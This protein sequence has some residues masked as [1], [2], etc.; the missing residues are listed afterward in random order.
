MVMTIGIVLNNTNW[1]L[2]ILYPIHYEEIIDKYAIEYNLDPHLI[3]GIIRT[4][5]KFNEKAR[6]SKDARGLMQIA[7]ITGKWASEKLGMEN[8]DEAILFTPDVNIKIGCWYLNKLKEEFGGDLQLMLAAYNGGSGN[9]NK[10]LQDTKYSEDGK[11]LTDIP[12]AE[13]KA[14]V[15]KVIKSYKV[16]RI[17]YR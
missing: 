14:Y 11:T 15:K 1:L 2:K 17:V 5:S 12:F 9:V 6:S 10:W 4:E 7:P 13:T 16:Y 8:Y 3:A